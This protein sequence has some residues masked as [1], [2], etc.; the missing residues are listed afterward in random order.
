MISSPFDWFRTRRY[1]ARNERETCVCSRR[2]QDI[3]DNIWR[4]TNKTEDLIYPEFMYKCKDCESFSVVN[5]YFPIEKYVEHSVDSMFIDEKKEALNSER[6]AWI[7]SMY[8]LSDKP[9]LYDLGAGEGCFSHIFANNFPGGKVFSVEPDKKVESKFYGKRSNVYFVPEYILPFLE[10]RAAREDFADLM[11]LTDVMEH[12]VDPE[13]MISAM[14]KAL[15]PNGL[16][17]ITVPNAHT[18]QDPVPQHVRRRQLDWRRANR[19]CQHLWLLTP[20]MVESLVAE[21]FEILAVSD[22][23][24]RLRQDSVYTTILARKR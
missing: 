2:R 9:I 10:D 3:P 5:L 19:T 21:A 6:L 11:V 22:F 4:V 14:A 18:F 24:T 1:L 20:R 17:Y 23:E 8:N 12:V 13:D 7:K 16:V 15:A